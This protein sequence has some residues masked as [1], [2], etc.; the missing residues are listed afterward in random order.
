[1]LR[2]TATLSGMICV[3]EHLTHGEYLKMLDAKRA[4]SKKSYSKSEG[5]L[6][7]TLFGRKKFWRFLRMA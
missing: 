7:W 4:D 3:T 5:E 1:M 2:N 6:I